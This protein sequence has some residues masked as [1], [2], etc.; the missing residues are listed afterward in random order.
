MTKEELQLWYNF[1]NDYP[2]RFLK[3]KVIDDYIV[4]FYCHKAKLVIELDGTQHYDL[5]HRYHDNVRTANLE[6]RGLKVIRI[7]NNEILNNFSGVCE[8]IDSVVRERVTL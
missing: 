1:L 6:S 2:I 8:Y 3:Q 5:K 7:Q 4:D